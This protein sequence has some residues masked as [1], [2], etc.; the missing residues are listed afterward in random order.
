MLA[1][2]RSVQSTG[3]SGPSLISVMPANAE[4]GT[5][6]QSSAATWLSI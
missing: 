5:L 6:E 4:A 1:A 2:D 3:F